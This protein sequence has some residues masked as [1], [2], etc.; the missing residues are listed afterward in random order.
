[1]QRLFIIILIGCLL[2]VRL[3]KDK[4]VTIDDLY[5]KADNVCQT[6]TGDAK[7]D[8]VMNAMTVECENKNLTLDVCQKLKETW[9]IQSQPLKSH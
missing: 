7:F 5:K 2:Q 3:H 4:Q 6:E 1:M 8:C 9:K